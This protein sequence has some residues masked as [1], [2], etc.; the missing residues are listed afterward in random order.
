LLSRWSFTAR[1]SDVVHRGT[2]WITWLLVARGE[3]YR[4][5]H[6]MESQVS[7]DDGAKDD[8]PTRLKDKDEKA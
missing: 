1:E 6:H 8:P 4:I 2:S 5:F 7:L 3:N